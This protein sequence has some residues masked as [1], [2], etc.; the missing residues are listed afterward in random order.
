[1]VILSWGEEENECIVLLGGFPEATRIVY[2]YKHNE[3]FE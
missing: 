2:R 1:M 3:D